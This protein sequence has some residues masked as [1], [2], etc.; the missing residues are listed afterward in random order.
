M[1]FSHDRCLLKTQSVIENR[2]NYVMILVFILFD[3][4][5][6]THWVWQTDAFWVKKKRKRKSNNGH[7]GGRE[8]IL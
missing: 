3:K 6:L 2:S 7:P 1:Y 5:D 4:E 8:V